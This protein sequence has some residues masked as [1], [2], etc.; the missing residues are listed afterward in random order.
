MRPRRRARR[1][2]P[3]ESQRIPH[4]HLSH[5]RPEQDRGQPDNEHETGRQFDRER[6]AA[7]GSAEIETGLVMA[8]LQRR[9]NRQ[10][11]GSG[12]WCRTCER[13][14]KQEQQLAGRTGH[15]LQAPSSEQFKGAT[16]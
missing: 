1:A 8:K 7:M 3:S 13:I 2:A 10:T 11:P 6:V 15:R 12:R 5:A 4:G 9:L 14:D 16:Q